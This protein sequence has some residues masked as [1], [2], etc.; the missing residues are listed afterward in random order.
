MNFFTE[1]SILDPA[2]GITIEG[3]GKGEAGTI[4]HPSLNAKVQFLVI[5]TNDGAHGFTKDNDPTKY[6]ILGQCENKPP[7]PII[8]GIIDL[9][10]AR[11]KTIEIPIF[12]EKE[13][14]YY[15][16]FF[17]NKKSNKM[18]VKVQLKAKKLAPSN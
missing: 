9:P 10:A 8:N 2:Q 7:E 17:K 4:I 18:K 12:A 1:D 6:R 11:N 3:I 14:K 16:I 13:Y 15:W 5:T